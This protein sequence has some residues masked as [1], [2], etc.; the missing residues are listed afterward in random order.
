MSA[1]LPANKDLG[2]GGCRV[3]PGRPNKSGTG[4]RIPLSPL[5]PGPTPDRSNPMLTTIHIA[6]A[7]DDDDL[8]WKEAA[9][10]LGK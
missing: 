9:Q 4:Q 6:A 5:W 7:S 8:G 10:I 1:V 2:A 3:H